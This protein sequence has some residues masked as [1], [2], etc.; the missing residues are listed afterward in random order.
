MSRVNS[1]IG[2]GSK[3]SSWFSRIDV[4]MGSKR[5]SSSNR[6]LMPMG[7]EGGEVEWLLDP[8]IDWWVIF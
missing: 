8:V 6:M 3:E 7:G 1:G 4:I 5:S 2:A